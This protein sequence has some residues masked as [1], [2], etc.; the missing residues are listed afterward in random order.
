MNHELL[1]SKGKLKIG[2]F[3]ILRS[4]V[5]WVKVARELCFALI[6][7]G[8]ELNI[9]ERK[10]FLYNPKFKLK[11]ELEEK[12]LPYQQPADIVFTFEHPRNYHYLSGNF[13]IGLLVYESTKV[14]K[15]WV[16][17]VNE[18]LDLLLVPSTFCS[19]IFI[20]G[21]VNKERVKILPYGVDHNIFHSQVSPYPFKTKKHFK[22]LNISLP[23]KRKGIDILL[24]A[25]TRAFKKSHDVCLV[26]KTNYNP[27]EFR[28]KHFK[29]EYDDIEE[30]V[31]RYKNQID[32][33]EI[34]LINKKEPDEIIPSYYKG[35]N[36][37]VHCARAEGF[38]MSILEAFASYI[39][40]IATGWGG[41]L[42]F[43]NEDNAFLLKYNLRKANEIQYDNQ[44]AQ[45]YIC[46]PN[47]EDLM[48]KMSLVYNGGKEITR[49]IE[50]AY[51]TSLNYSWEK[52][53]L[54]LL[55]ILSKSKCL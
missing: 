43:C 32:A 7:L 17:Y 54:K 2:Y 36:C 48:E 30:L 22:F 11:K 24:E 37:F 53:V 38:G 49:R 14:P 41:H 25:Y 10:G 5:S 45:S 50:N 35:V 55:E 33:P 4:P 27:K 20:E 21:G 19:R 28:R 44:D 39:P 3:G 18:Y 1:F 26:I 16:E 52:I 34:L 12:I 46:E 15:K 9:Y 42:D 13:K 23:H 31:R 29:W 8:V 40:V 51:S 6:K 47:V